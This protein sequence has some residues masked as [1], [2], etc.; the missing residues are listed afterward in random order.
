MIYNFTLIERLLLSKD[1]L[2]H[3]ILDSL[4]LVVAGRALQVAVKLKIFDVMKTRPESLD[5]ICRKAR[6]SRTGALVLLDCLS[7]MG[8]V[9]INASRYELT[10]RAKKYLLSDSSSRLSNMILF[11]EN[12]FESLLKLDNYVK[13]GGPKLENLDI[14]TKDQWVIFNKAMAE[15]ASLDVK[16]VIG[17]LPLSRKYKKLL[18]LGGSHGIHSI[19]SCKKVP[20][21]SAEILDLNPTKANAERIIKENKM[22]KRVKFRAGDFLTDRLGEGYDVVLA[23]NVIHGLTDSKNEE[24]AK[25]VYKSINHRG[26]YVILDQIKEARGKSELSRFIPVTMGVMLFN[27]S[28]GRTYSLTEV[29]EWLKTVGFARIEFQKLRS[30]GNALII[31]HKD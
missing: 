12:V 28:G 18:D 24:L 8:Y 6:I 10:P 11:S 3:P 16:E 9:R 23:F 13:Q 17:K 14:F 4:N 21:L 22:S 15:V 25:K 7:V 5:T 29:Q 2:P 19:E 31:G 30:P 27:Q 1:I 26:I 20:G